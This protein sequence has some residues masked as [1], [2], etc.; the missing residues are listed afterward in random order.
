MIGLVTALCS[1]A[2]YTCGLVM[3]QRALHRAPELSPRHPMRLARTLLGNRRWLCGCLLAAIGSVGLIVSLGLAPVSVVQPAFAGGV[4]TGL[5]VAALL[6]GEPITRGER[7]ALGMMPLALLLLALSSSEAADPGRTADQPLLLAASLGSLPAAM[8][9][10]LLA[11]ARRTSAAMSAVLLAVAAGLAQGTAGLQGKGLGGL[12]ADHGPIGAV[13]PAL[14]SP[15]PY[16]YALGWAVGIALFQTSMQRTRATVTTP[17][18]NV[19]GNVV[20]VLFGTLVFAETLPTE[21][22]PLALRLTGLG[23]TLLVVALVRG[24]AGQAAA[25]TARQRGATPARLTDGA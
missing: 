6:L 19:V 16:L 2:I 10:A 7:L 3:E 22:L 13:L 21:P 9:I 23:L 25:Q 17:V 14:L 4:A 24:Q 8:A 20:T 12:L 11:G 18:A 1:A 15:F 5:L